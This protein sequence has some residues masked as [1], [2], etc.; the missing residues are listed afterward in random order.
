M[1]K[2]LRLLMVLHMPWDRNLGAPRVQLE[3][4]DELR[5]RGHMVDKFDWHD[6]FPREPSRVGRVVGA[7]FA[8]RARRFVRSV[9]AR[10]DIIDAQQGDLPY[11]KEQLGFDGLLVA[12]SC[13]L[14]RFYRDFERYARRRWPEERGRRL[15]RPLR[16]YE[17]WR[18]TARERRSLE[19]ADLVNVPNS[20]EL[21]FVRDAL[22][23]GDR[24][25]LVP[26]GVER[27][28]LDALRREAAPPA[29]RLA[30][31][32]VVF[33]G[34]WS[35]RKGSADWRAIVARIRA[36]EPKTRFTFLGTGVENERVRR[37]L[38][39]ADG[40]ATTVVPRYETDELPR[41]LR[42]AT[43]GVL[44]SYVE[45]FGLGV[46]EQLAAGIP[47][48]AYDAPGA[49]QTAGAVH[50]RLL[51]PRG[52]PHSLADRVVE[53][54]R[55]GVGEY[56]GL[57]ERCAAAARRW[58]LDALVSATLATYADRLERLR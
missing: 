26:N 3:L 10:Y 18:E 46:V 35:V 43:V 17:A 6:A 41:L 34:R 58:S 28:R 29:Q 4:A 23:L 2:P 15:G 39:D 50:A 53:I 24:C 36:E 37:D 5:S 25:V 9:A 30:S 32:E 19:C 22:G 42:G 44:P 21:A 14:Y 12:R 56:A 40:R 33:I 1:D 51:T 7:S 52:D 48:V 57:S 38:G 16:G 49:R 13:G 11:P 47:T 54:L 45:G 20:D 8:P 31:R 55:A 27:T